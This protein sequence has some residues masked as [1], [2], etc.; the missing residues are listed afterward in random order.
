[1]NTK[2]QNDTHAQSSLTGR[3]LEGLGEDTVTFLIPVRLDSVVRLENLL[4]TT[5]FLLRHFS[6]CPIKVLEADNYNNGF[7]Q[8]LLS[9]KIDYTFVE[10]KDPVFYRTKYLNLMIEKVETPFLAIWDADVIIP[11]EQIAEAIEKLCEGYEVA[12]PYNGTFLDTS[13]VIRWQFLQSRKVSLLQKQKSKMHPIY[14]NRELKGGA[15]LVNTEAHKRA[16]KENENFYGWGQEDFE[17]YERW[18][19]LRYR[20]YR[21]KGE[22]FHLSHERGSNSTFRSLE[23]NVKSNQVL[24][25]TRDSSKK[26]L[27]KNKL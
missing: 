1:M 18:S 8:K 9:K 14:G 23:Q 13:D 22:L 21:S 16:G 20:I 7:I 15:V 2:G 24:F 6:D 19:I 12:Y 17:R 4:M 27:L 5:Q 25:R 10:D 3:D 26:E 11:K